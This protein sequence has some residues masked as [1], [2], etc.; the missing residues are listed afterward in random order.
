[1][2]KLQGLTMNRSTGNRALL[3]IAIVAGLVAA[4]LVFL[5]LQSSDDGG[6]ALLTSTDVATIDVVVA[7]G[8]IAA[9]TKVTESMLEV[10]SFPLDLRIENAFAATG[11]VVG[12]VTNVAV[13]QGEQFTPNKIGLAV[14]DKGLSGVV[15]PGMRGV[16]VAVDEVTAVGGNLLPGD[17]VDI[18]TA[19][20]IK[21]GPGV[22][23]NQYILRTEVLVQDVEV[24]SVAQEAQ[25]PVAQA[26]PAEDGQEPAAITYTSGAVP[27]DV[28]DQ[29]NARTITV[30]LSPAETQLV[31][32]KQGYA[33]EVWAV[34][35]AFG[36][37][38]TIELEPLDVL[39]FE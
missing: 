34:L 38:E 37:E 13:A 17:R 1:M 28:D 10:V 4:V 19:I 11:P 22:G 20:R 31:V 3:L 35:R 27:S 14:P 2:A 32:S 15:P 5:A 9:G 8:D 30:A 21:G 16:A 33:E 36:D 25:K 12:E 7:S 23:E 39:I 26:A 29:P 6:T 18:L 24:L